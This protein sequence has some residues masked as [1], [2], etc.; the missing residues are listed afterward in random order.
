MIRHKSDHPTKNCTIEGCDRPLRAKARC[1]T[2]Y[3]QLN[4]NRHTKK[5]VACAYCGTEVLKHSGGGRI[6]G[7]V[8]S[9]Q[10]R[11]WLTTPYCAIPKDHWAR[12]Y[13]KSSAWT[14]PTPPSPPRFQPQVRECVWCGGEFTAS[15]GDHQSCST[16]CKQ[17]AKAVRR[18]GR[19]HNAPGTYTWAEVMHLWISIDRRCSYCD[20]QDTVI[21]PDHVIP[22]SK[23]GSNSLTNIVPSC[24]PCNSD[25]RDLLINEWYADRARRGLEPRLL[26]PAFRHLTHAL[27]AA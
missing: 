15:R 1:S 25:K 17:K 5:M 2:H 27:L 16:Y 10:C 12:M 11:T 14:P 26:N 23:G 13:G 6:Y 9:D 4:P 24:K 19:E 21:E 22:L 7:Q 18:R 20:K 8:C 3:N